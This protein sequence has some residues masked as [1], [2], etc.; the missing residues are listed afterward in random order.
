MQI[1]DRVM[2]NRGSNMGIEGVIAERYIGDFTSDCPSDRGWM[3]RIDGE[4]S[5][6]SYL[7]S[8]LTLINNKK[9]MNIKEKFT[10]AFKSEP[11]KSFRKLEITNGDDFLTED[12]QKIFLSWLLKKHGPDF[13]KEV[14]DDLLKEKEDESK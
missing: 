6:S 11:E 5:H 3:I 4:N 10:L 13:K 8:W 9:T 14:V 2:L 12:G 7:E 1:G